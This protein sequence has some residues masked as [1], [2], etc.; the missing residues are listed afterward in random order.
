MI[1]TNVIIR[2]FETPRNKVFLLNKALGDVV[3][4]MPVNVWQVL[5][6]HPNSEEMGCGRRRNFPVP[7]MRFH[8]STWVLKRL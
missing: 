8:R 5:T 7:G 1:N 3:G 4:N 2:W 6:S